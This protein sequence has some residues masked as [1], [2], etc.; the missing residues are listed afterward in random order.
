M[1]KAGSRQRSAVPK[2]DAISNQPVDPMVEAAGHLPG[3]RK[4]V[5]IS[6]PLNPMGILPA[7]YGIHKMEPVRFE[8]GVLIIEREKKEG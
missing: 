5:V 4:G 8:R 3:P 2:G 7:W 6:I 1:R